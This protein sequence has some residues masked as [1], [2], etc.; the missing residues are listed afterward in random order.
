VVRC[1]L[2]YFHMIPEIERKRKNA[3]RARRWRAANPERARAISRSGELTRSKLRNRKP[4]PSATR[5]QVVSYEKKRERDRR[6]HR[7]R[8]YGVTEPQ[9]QALLAASSGL[10]E[11]CGGTNRLGIDHSHTTGKPRGLLCRACNVGLGY[12]KESSVLL[13]SA[14]HY[15]LTRCHSEIGSNQVN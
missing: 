11:I 9:Y 3:E 12:L 6:S 2:V 13:Q 8:M 15:V 10:C 7:Y 14:I 4:G 5:A 1:G